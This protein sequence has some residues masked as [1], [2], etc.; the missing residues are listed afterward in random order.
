MDARFDYMLLDRLKQ[1]CKYFINN[2]CRSAKSL[3]AGDVQKQI[4]KM[5]ELWDGL[6]VKPVWLT[7][8]QINELA[9]TMGAK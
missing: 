3:W 4:D 7:M 5:R 2:G 9:K 1:D 8:E 6:K